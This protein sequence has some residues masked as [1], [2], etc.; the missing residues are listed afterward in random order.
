[1]RR[2]AVL[3]FT[4]L[5]TIAAA[6]AVTGPARAATQLGAPGCAVNYSVPAAYSGGFV[7][8]ITVE[9]FNFQPRFGWELSF[10]FVSPQ[11][12]VVSVPSEQWF[13]SGENVVIENQSQ[14]TPANGALQVGFVGSDGTAN[15]PPVNFIFDGVAC[16]SF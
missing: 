9:I 5:A 1:M 4:T 10:Q 7:A 8:E 12:Q 11:Q 6:C 3:V 14:P 16:T 13:Q 15:P 2:L